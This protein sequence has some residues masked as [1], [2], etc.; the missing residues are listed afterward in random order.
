MP[1]IRGLRTQTAMSFFRRFDSAISNF[2]SEW[3]IPCATLCTENVF[4]VPVTLLWF[5]GAAFERSSNRRRVGR[6]RTAS[7]KKC[8]LVLGS[9]SL[10]LGSLPFF[11]QIMHLDSHR[12]TID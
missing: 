5:P 1:A 7:T 8:L 10:P 4:S 12:I 9:F 3:Q 2:Q 6:P 11:R